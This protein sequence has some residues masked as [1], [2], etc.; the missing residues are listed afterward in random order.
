[1]K[2]F[3]LVVDLAANASDSSET[4]KE[5]TKIFEGKRRRILG[6]RLS[7]GAV[8]SKHKSPE[9]ITVLCVDGAGTFY[10][11]A[12]LEES[13]PMKRGTLVALAANVEHEARA[14]PDMHLLVT[15]FTGE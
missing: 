13:Q 1:M 5:V 11:G 2:N 8:L 10:A 4:D 14:E 15:R 12:D 9:P 7:N 6:I 3:E